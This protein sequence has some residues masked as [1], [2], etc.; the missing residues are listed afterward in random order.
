[1]GCTKPSGG[2]YDCCRRKSWRALHTALTAFP[3]ELLEKRQ[4]CSGHHNTEQNVLQQAAARDDVLLTTATACAVFVA[5][6]VRAQWPSC[7]LSPSAPPPPP[8]SFLVRLAL[9]AGAKLGAPKKDVWRQEQRDGFDSPSDVAHKVTP[10]RRAPWWV[11]WW[12]A[13]RVK[14]EEGR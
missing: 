12:A 6:C 1:M 9:A 7:S 14:E 4:H 3:I 10:P 11:I 8:P 5:G 13:E 2:R